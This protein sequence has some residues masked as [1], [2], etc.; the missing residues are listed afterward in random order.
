LIQKFIKFA[1]ITIDLSIQNPPKTNKIPKK[2]QISKQPKQR[3]CHNSAVNPTLIQL[4]I[5][6]FLSNIHFSHFIVFRTFEEVGV[7]L[8]FRFIF[9]C[10]KRR[11][12]TKL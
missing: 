12:F 4:F 2:I 9:I 10:F 11:N 8:V 6:F 1:M 5:I 7:A 3:T